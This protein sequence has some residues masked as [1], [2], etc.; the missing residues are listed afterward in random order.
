M[1]KVYYKLLIICLASLASIEVQAQFER[2][3]YS[4]HEFGVAVKTGYLGN[5]SKLPYDLKAEYSPNVEA[6]IQYDY[7]FKQKWSV[8]VG[9]GY[10]IMNMKYGKSNFSG[11]DVYRDKEGDSFDF[12]Y[13]VRQFN[14]SVKMSQISIPLTIQY[15]SG[16]EN[17]IYARA[18]VQIGLAMNGKVHSELNDVTT[19]GYFPKY[20]LEMD[21][22][23]YMGFGSFDQLKTESDIE[24]DTKYSVIGELGYM[25][26]IGNKQNIYIGAYFDFGLNNQVKSSDN[27]SSKLLSY[28]ALSEDV[29]K[30]SS[31]SQNKNYQIKNYQIGVKLRYSFGL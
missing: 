27:Y 26:N 18:G 15:R 31:A 8:G 9:V 23:K 12:K 20:N 29:L 4:K 17:G 21:A 28:D 11:T 10:G 2:V 16:N 19:K 25:Y 7:F 24:F 30:V 5:L 22:P 14:E 13:T 3:K 6:A 1:K